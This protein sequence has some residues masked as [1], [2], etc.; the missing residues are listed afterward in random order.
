MNKSILPIIEADL[1]AGILNNHEIGRKHN[2]RHE[3]V[4]DHRK[5]L[6]LPAHKG[7]KR[8]PVPTERADIEAKLAIAQKLADKWTRRA[9]AL[10]A[11]LEGK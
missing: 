8:H 11:L 7:G 2:V 6:G 5:K 1:R 3:T 9:K 10:V 4:G